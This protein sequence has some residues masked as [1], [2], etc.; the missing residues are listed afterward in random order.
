MQVGPQQYTVKE[1]GVVGDNKGAFA[2][3]A[4]EIF[5]PFASCMV[6]QLQSFSYQGAQHRNRQNA[7]GDDRTG[8]TYQGNGG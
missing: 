7:D 2:L 5:Q 6:D 1:G 8:K 4:A 3:A